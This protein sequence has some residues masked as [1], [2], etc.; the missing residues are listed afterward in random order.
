[1]TEQTIADEP[2]A[3]LT[4]DAAHATSSLMNGCGEIIGWLE[5]AASSRWRDAT[6]AVHTLNL[7]KHQACRGVTIE[8]R[9]LS[10]CD[11]TLTVFDS[12]P[13]AT[14]FLRLLNVDRFSN[15][16]HHDLDIAQL[17]AFQCYKTGAHGISP[18]TRCKMK[19]QSNHGQSQRQKYDLHGIPPVACANYI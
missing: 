19:A 14:R 15:G 4:L 11:G 12:M 9:W 6:A 3:S 7:N 16:G 18:C 1:M 17:D 5:L 13:T 10:G 2:Q 8:Q